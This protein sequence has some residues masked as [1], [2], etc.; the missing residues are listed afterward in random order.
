M[1]KKGGKASEGVKNFDLEN[2]DAQLSFAPK[3]S[4]KSSKFTKIAKNENL[5]F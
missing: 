4:K 5:D 2:M 3:I 1:S